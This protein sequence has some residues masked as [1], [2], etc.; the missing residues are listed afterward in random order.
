MAKKELDRFATNYKKDI[1]IQTKLM[2]ILGGSVLISCLVIFFLS[3][4]VFDSKLLNHEKERIEINGVGVIKIIEDWRLQLSQY[5]YLL[6]VNPEISEAI[7]SDDGSIGPLADGILKNLDL[8]FYAI[9]DAKGTILKGSGVSG[10]ITGCSAVSKAIRGQSTWSYEGIGNQTYAIIAANPITYENRL[11]GTVVC[12][13]ALDNGLLAA[14]AKDGY[15]LESTV[16]KDDLRIDTTLVDKNG[17]KMT[18]TKID[19]PEVISTVLKNGKNFIGEVKINGTKYVSSYE[20]LVSEDGTVTGM[21]FVAK[22]LEAIEATKLTTMKIVAPVAVILIIVLVISVGAFVRWLMWRINNVTKSLEEM[23]TGEADLTKRCKLFI[24]DEIGFLVIQFD[25]FCDKLQQI[26]SEV[27]NSKDELNGTGSD[28]ISAIDETSTAI[29]EISTGITSIH[30]Q[31][32]NSSNSVQQ[33][34]TAVD[35]VTGNISVLDSMI[36]NQSEN[37]AQAASAV[38]Q[39]IGNISS[40]NTSVEKMAVSFN[41]LTNNA[42]LG[43]TKQ[44]SVNER[45]QQIEEQSQMLQEANHAISSIAAQTNLLAMNAA[46]EA[47]HAGDAGKG[48]SVVADEIRKLSETSAAQS[49]TIGDQLKKIKNSISEVVAA[50]AESSQAFSEV[51]NKIKETDQLVIQI[52]SAME[53]QTEGSKQISES[54]RSMN[55]STGEVN[56]ASKNMAQKNQIIQNEVKKLQ[57]ITQEMQSSMKE[58]AASSEKI[59]ETDRELG[60]MSEQVQGSITKI[61]SQIDLF[62]V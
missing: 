41:D 60:N 27:K 3:I 19:N 49:K 17:K 31:I 2:G 12:G 54:L 10:N 9:T 26:I 50:S 62:K 11:V 15:D 53:E 42:E 59:S 21:L 18:G 30:D 44:Q 39:M 28:L 20:P 13:Y 4:N 45:I 61:G 55:E 34:A 56:A 7:Y 35:E 33:T 36:E 1:Q 57:D 52:K 37:V 48:F 32:I 6:S 58:I 38:E 43:F 47:A 22:T 29:T 5:S 46:I 14:E 25:A 23:A 40:V 24:R 16:F 51:S 8:D